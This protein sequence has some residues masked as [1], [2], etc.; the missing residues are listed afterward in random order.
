MS[1]GR[2][3]NWLPMSGRERAN[4]GA[5]VTFRNAKGESWSWTRSG[6]VLEVIRDACDAAELRDPTN[7]CVCIS[8][9]TSIYADL[10]GRPLTDLNHAV[11]HSECATLARAGRRYMIHPVLRGSEH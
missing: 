8:T 3:D 7:L 1:S 6:P 2:K 10:V 9:P 11:T 5:S 4:H